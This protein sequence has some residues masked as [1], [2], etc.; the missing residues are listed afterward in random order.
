MPYNLTS[1]AEN[2]TGI[3]SFTQGVNNELMS[4]ALGILLLIGLTVVALI[5]FLQS[6]GDAN[7]SVAATGFIM[8]TLSIFLRAVDMIPDLAMFIALIIAAAG[9]AFAIKKRNV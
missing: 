9:I 6:T 4:G 8:F 1:I 3:A 2:T 7:K 5:A